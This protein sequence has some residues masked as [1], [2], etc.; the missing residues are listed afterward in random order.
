MVQADV[1]LGARDGKV[2]T[3]TVAHPLITGNTIMYLAGI[4]R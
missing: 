1:L 2:I 4:I 3:G